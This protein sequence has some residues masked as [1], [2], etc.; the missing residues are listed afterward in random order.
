MVNIYEVETQG[1]EPASDSAL[2]LHD[3]VSARCSK[4]KGLLF[5]CSTII[6]S[7]KCCNMCV[8]APRALHQPDAHG[9]YMQAGH[10]RK[11]N[12]SVKPA[13]DPEPDEQA[14]RKRTF[15][16]SVKLAA[17][18]E[19]DIVPTV[20]SQPMGRGHRIRRATD[21]PKGS[22]QQV[23]FDKAVL[24]SKK[25]A[26]APAGANAQRAPKEARPAFPDETGSQSGAA[27]EAVKRKQGARNDS[28]NP[29]RARSA[30]PDEA[31]C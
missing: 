10:K 11:P 3:L 24:A 20:E 12:R 8:Q 29:K 19:P 30:L 9:S 1:G 17:V 21:A 26:A 15:D 28:P 18:P 31:D 27:P 22:D 5:P 16:R 13:A 23:M 14:G 7:G 2:Q 4:H 25:A 6:H